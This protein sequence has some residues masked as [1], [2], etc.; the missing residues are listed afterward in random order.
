MQGELVKFE[1]ILNFK[2]NT[3]H[4]F[5]LLFKLKKLTLLSVVEN[6]A[7]L[8]YLCLDMWYIILEMI[9]HPLEW[10]HF[11]LVCK[12]WYFLFW[13]YFAQ[14]KKLKT[15]M[16]NCRRIDY[17]DLYIMTDTIKLSCKFIN[18]A[19]MV[20]FDDDKIVNNRYHVETTIRLVQAI[21]SQLTQIPF[22]A[23]LG[24]ELVYFDYDTF[25]Q[26]GS[27][28][29]GPYMKFKRL[30]FIRMIPNDD[31]YAITYCR[32]SKPPFKFIYKNNKIT[33]MAHSINTG[34]SF[35]SFSID[36]KNI[37]P[38]HSISSIIHLL[39]DTIQQ[40]F[41]N[42]TESHNQVDITRAFP[43]KSF[44]MDLI[45]FNITINSLEWLHKSPTLLFLTLTLNILNNSIRTMT[46]TLA[47]TIPQ[48]VYLFWQNVL[49]KLM[50]HTIILS[51]NIQNTLQEVLDHFDIDQYKRLWSFQIFTDIEQSNTIHLIIDF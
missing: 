35:R 24:K 25:T 27:R 15:T 49:K 10:Y 32:Q 19:L 23:M 29:H 39:L 31:I 3:F 51:L 17:C 34:V 6:D 38:L 48:N 13:H 42:R 1:E 36:K 47:I 16:Y 43:D 30:W 11:K 45:T 2:K 44:Y 22:S 5:D 28:K 41:M 37:V 8:Q 26:I 50:E 46:I 18:T 7:D 21:K 9:Q 12:S 20:P 14:V 33:I 4:D 40:T